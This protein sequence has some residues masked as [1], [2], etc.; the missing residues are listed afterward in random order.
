MGTF[1]NPQIKSCHYLPWLMSAPTRVP[2]GEPQEGNIE[3]RAFLHQLT[4]EALTLNTHHG[5]FV[6]TH[7]QAIYTNE[8]PYKCL[9]A[10]FRPLCVRS[11]RM[12]LQCPISVCKIY[13]LNHRMQ[14]LLVFSY[15][16]SC[17]CK[18]A[19]FRLYCATQTHLSH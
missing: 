12:L 18:F 17:V 8:C 13:K 6:C 5:H 19:S 7:S 10:G 4:S 9:S 16:Y 11:C 15:H 3:K 2:G 1:T 14:G